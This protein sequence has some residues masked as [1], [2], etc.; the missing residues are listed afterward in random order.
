[1]CLA[2]SL[3]LIGLFFF[4]SDYVIGQYVLA[5]NDPQQGALVVAVGWEMVLWL[6]PVVVAPMLLAGVVSVW[7]ARR[8]GRCGTKG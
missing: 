4:Y 8:C 3:A 1:M 2:I 7:V 6:W 5:V